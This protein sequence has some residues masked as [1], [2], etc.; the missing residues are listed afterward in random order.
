MYDAPRRPRRRQVPSFFALTEATGKF[1]KKKAS[2]K[3]P[4]PCM[5]QNP[6]GRAIQRRFSELRRGHPPGSI[7]WAPECYYSRPGG[8]TSGR[9]PTIV[10][11]SA[12]IELL[13]WT[14]ATL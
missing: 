12:S 13:Q 11:T 1:V 3:Q 5:K 6:Q 10:S 9:S 2:E 4:H 8:A 7:L 14:S